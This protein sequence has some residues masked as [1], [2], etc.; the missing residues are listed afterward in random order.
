MQEN[1]IYTFNRY[2]REQFGEKIY[3]LSLNP[4]T[5]CPNRD[6]TVGL[7]GC[8][9]CSA[10]GSGEFAPAATLSVTEQ[11]AE[12]KRLVAHKGAKRYLAYFQAFSGTYGP[13]PYL[14]Q[15]Y[16][17]ALSGEDIVGL[18]IATRPDCISDSVIELLVRLREEYRKPIWIE[19]GLQTMQDSVAESV[20]RGYSLS[21]FEATVNRLH[22][23]AI[24]IIVHMILGLPGESPEQMIQGVGEVCH[25]P[26]AGIKLHLLHILRG[27]TLAE[28]YSS[29]PE[30]FPL[31]DLDSY[32]DTLLAAIERIPGNVVIHRMTGDGKKSLL[33]APEFTKNKKAV[34]NAISKRMEQTDCI[35]GRLTHLPYKGDAICNPKP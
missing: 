30:H 35:Q 10:G 19:L 16:R 26:I 13:L 33:L 31:M 17:E 24:P 7:G 4:G 34:L 28:Q 27:T 11:L 23:A 9:F 32:I 21:T 20:N 12:A 14:E 5:G 18:S 8:H 29:S 2:M 6:G 3:R 22:E 15:I 25:Y 1:R